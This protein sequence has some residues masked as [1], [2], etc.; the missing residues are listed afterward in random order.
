MLQLLKCVKEQQ[1]EFY[2]YLDENPEDEHMQKQIILMG[3]SNIC[4]IPLILFRCNKNNFYKIDVSPNFRIGN[5][6]E[7]ELLMGM[8]QKIYLKKSIKMKI[9][10]FTINK[11]IY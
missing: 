2:K 11:Y 6:T 8:Y 10:I 3:K 5:Q 7:I 4:T 1:K 9:V